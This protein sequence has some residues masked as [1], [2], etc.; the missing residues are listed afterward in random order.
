[1]PFSAA[2]LFL[3][4]QVVFFRLLH[5]EASQSFVV[6]V[7]CCDHESD[8]AHFFYIG[9]SHAFKEFEVFHNVVFGGRETH[10]ERDGAHD[11]VD[12]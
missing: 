6:H 7:V 5:G 10:F 2:V 12:F 11:A 3:W 9:N 8:G 1:M 4:D